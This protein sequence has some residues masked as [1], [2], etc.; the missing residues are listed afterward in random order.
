MN[1]IYT[2]SSASLLAATAKEGDASDSARYLASSLRR[3]RFA[4]SISASVAKAAGGSLLRSWSYD[5]ILTMVGL[6]L[7]Q[8]GT[9]RIVPLY[10]VSHIACPK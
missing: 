2:G 5:S 6:L 9:G 3:N 10:A 4:I 1:F 7:M 8:E